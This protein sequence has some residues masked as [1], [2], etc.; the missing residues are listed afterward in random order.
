MS[1]KAAILPPWTCH[2]E[3]LLSYYRM[4]KEGAHELQCVSTG[5]PIKENASPAPAGNPPQDG[6]HRAGRPQ[7]SLPGGLAAPVRGW[8]RPRP[9]DAPVVHGGGRQHLGLSQPC[10]P[11]AV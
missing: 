7:S 8:V 1:N 9:Q 10:P 2:S 5:T 3:H 6:H 11:T 4:L